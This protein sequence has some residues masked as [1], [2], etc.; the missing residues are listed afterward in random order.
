MKP[1]P[2]IELKPYSENDLPFLRRNNAPE[3]TEFLGGPESEEKLLQRH[4]KYVNFTDTGT[5]HMFVIWV[6]GKAAGSAGFWEKEWNGMTVWEAGWGVL[7]EFQ[8]RGIAVAA[9]QAL[10]EKARADGRHRFMHAYPKIENLA[11]NALCRRAGFEL[12]G[13]CDF[14]YPKGV[15]IR[16][17]DWR[18]DLL[19]DDNT[20]R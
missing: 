8:G 11:S 4:Q 19:G 18:I 1:L 6:D 20:K 17:N 9:V 5:E 12:M 15:P 7:P 16:C 10:F 14:E 2:S 13:E 3:M